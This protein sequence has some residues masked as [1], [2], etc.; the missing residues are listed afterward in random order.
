VSG[1]RPRLAAV[2]D[3]ADDTVRE[4][5]AVLEKS[6]GYGKFEGWDECR[7]VGNG[8]HDAKDEDSG[9]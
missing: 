4:R 2:R 8:E 1:W 5:C 9:G 6:W 7:G 3:W